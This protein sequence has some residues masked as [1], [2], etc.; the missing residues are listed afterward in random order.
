L[1]KW[2][3]TAFMACECG[4]EDQTVELNTQTKSKTIKTWASKHNLVM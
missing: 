1:H 3:K 4:E 2:G